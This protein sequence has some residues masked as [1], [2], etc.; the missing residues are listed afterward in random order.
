VKLRRSD[1]ATLKVTALDGNGYPAGAAGTAAEIKL[2]PG[3]L[4]YAI[5]K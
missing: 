2:Q 3:V 5:T 1:A 4:S